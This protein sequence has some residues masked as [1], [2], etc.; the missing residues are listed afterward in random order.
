VTLCAL[1]SL[2]AEQV[3]MRGPNVAD[4]RNPETI[5]KS[6]STVALTR[7]AI[8]EGSVPRVPRPPASKGAQQHDATSPVA[9]IKVDA[10]GRSFMHIFS[11][12]HLGSVLLRL[13]I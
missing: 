13:T 2:Y 8:H 12:F 7:Q 4:P 9:E 3:L 5:R 6:H 11:C 10:P 1:V